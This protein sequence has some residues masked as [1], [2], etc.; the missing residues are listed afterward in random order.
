MKC[1]V[2]APGDSAAFRISAGGILENQSC[3]SKASEF[4]GH[5]VPGLFLEIGRKETD[6]FF[7]AS[8]GIANCVELDHLGA[9]VSSDLKHADHDGRVRGRAGLLD[10]SCVHVALPMAR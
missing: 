6:S 9:F 8:R 10:F 1:G 2:A 5:A 7:Y 3:R 4:H